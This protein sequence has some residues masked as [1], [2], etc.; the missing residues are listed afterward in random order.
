[1]LRAMP[2]ATLT[3]ELESR[4]VTLATLC[5][6]QSRATSLVATFS[7]VYAGPEVP[8]P[9]D[10]DL[11]ALVDEELGGQYLLTIPEAM[12][13]PTAVSIIETQCVCPLTI[14]VLPSENPGE[15][16]RAHVHL[17]DFFFPPE[18]PAAVLTTLAPF[19]PRGGLRLF[20][21]TERDGTQGAYDSSPQDAAH[22][23]QI[24]LLPLPDN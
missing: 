18:V 22:H 12:A 21:L 17:T 7:P 6:R 1:M 11:L 15:A 2:L 4:A 3:M 8:L 5:F 23:V 13:P 20:E 16:A 19:L 14:T 10:P 24:Q 9:Q